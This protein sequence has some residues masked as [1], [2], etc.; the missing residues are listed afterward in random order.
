MCS[1]ITLEGLNVFLDMF[2]RF[3]I[4]YNIVTL[5]LRVSR[6]QNLK[7]SHDLNDIRVR[8]PQ[9]VRGRGLRG[10]TGTRTTVLKTRTA[11]VSDIS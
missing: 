8:G 6:I 7:F 10:H 4:K 2:K 3:Y 5:F 11:M 1:H 9:G